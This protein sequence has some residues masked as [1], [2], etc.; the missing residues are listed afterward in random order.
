LLFRN[1][2]FFTMSPRLLLDVLTLKSKSAK[3]HRLCK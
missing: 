2:L 1:Y 3:H